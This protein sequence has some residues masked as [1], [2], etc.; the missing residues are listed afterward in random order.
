MFSHNTP[1]LHT[2][3]HRQGQLHIYTSDTET[4]ALT[5]WA[6]IPKVNEN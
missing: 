2:D 5:R 6:K 4:K 3:R 1:T